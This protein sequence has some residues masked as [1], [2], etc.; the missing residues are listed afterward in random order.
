[1]LI[2]DATLHTALD[3]AWR[4]AKVC[5]RF[6]RL[7]SRVNE[8]TFEVFHNGVGKA[9]SDHQVLY[10]E[11]ALELWIEE[12]SNLLATWIIGLHQG[13]RVNLNTEVPPP[14]QP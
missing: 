13:R 11:A 1:V 9:D 5:T 7:A 3:D 10:S 2:D 8:H 14:C 4:R 12:L 6:C